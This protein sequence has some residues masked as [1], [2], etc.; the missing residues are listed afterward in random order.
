MSEQEYD[1]PFADVGTEEV[2]AALQPP[3]PWNGEFP[4]AIIAA[5]GV[6]AKPEE[7]K[8][9]PHVKITLQATNTEGKSIKIPDRVLSQSPKARGL[10]IQFLYSFGLTPRDYRHASQLVGL[11]SR[12]RVGAGKPN[13][14]GQVFTE[15]KS[16]V[17]PK[18]TLQAFTPASA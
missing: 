16:Y 9:Y 7:N 6:A 11:V 17:V 14:A 2:Q 4:V 10:A 5:E 18:E 13:D 3:K 1:A 12:A 15:V 8:P